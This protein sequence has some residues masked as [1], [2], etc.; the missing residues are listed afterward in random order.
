[1]PEFKAQDALEAI[2]EGMTLAELP[3]TY[4][5]QA[6]ANHA[7][8]KTPFTPHCMLPFTPTSA[9][10]PN[11]AEP[12]LAEIPPRRIRHGS[13][14][15]ADDPEAAIHDDLAQHTERPKPFK[16]SKTAEDILTRERRASDRLDQF[17]GSR[18]DAPEAER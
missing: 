3:K 8:H 2:R 16:R 13:Y 1:M 17:R 6:L 5:V 9:S 10:C 18:E 4:G 14:S 11:L 15:S 12:T 7:T